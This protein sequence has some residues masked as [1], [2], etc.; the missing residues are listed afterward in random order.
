MAGL[1]AAKKGGSKPAADPQPKASEVI[2]KLLDWI[3]R[4]DIASQRGEP[5]PPFTT[6]TGTAIFPEDATE[7]LALAGGSFPTRGPTGGGNIYISP[8]YIYWAVRGVRLSRP[9]SPAVGTS[10]PK[11]PLLRR[12]RV[13]GRRTNGVLVRTACPPYERPRR[14]LRQEEERL[15]WRRQK[16]FAFCG[17][18]A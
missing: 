7:V 12:S 4:V 8:L 5:K 16:N 14:E 11:A 10:C 15:A 18:D 9:L 1:G 17:S 3:S 6:R 13:A 2:W